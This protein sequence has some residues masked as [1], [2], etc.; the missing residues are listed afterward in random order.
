MGGGGVPTTFQHSKTNEVQP[1]TK[2]DSPFDE[3]DF[4]CFERGEFFPDDVCVNV[5]VDVL[6][7]VCVTVCVSLLVP[8]FVFFSVL[9]EAR[10]D[11]ELF[12]GGGGCC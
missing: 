2:Q 3:G 11:S 1:N 4:L 6:V 12:C 7:D 9:E 8:F 10:L 5:C